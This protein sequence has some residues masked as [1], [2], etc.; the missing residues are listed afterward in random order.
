MKTIVK[1]D[2]IKNISFEVKNIYNPE[3]LR[4]RRGKFGLYIDTGLKE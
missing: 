2:L 1:G 3:T 4:E